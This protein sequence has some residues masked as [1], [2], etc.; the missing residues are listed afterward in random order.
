MTLCTDTESAIVDA[1]DQSA[2]EVFQMMAGVELTSIDSTSVNAGAQSATPE[3][4][5]TVVMGLSGDLQGSMIINMCETT[6][7]VWTGHLL[8]TE[9][10]SIDQ[11]VIDAVGELGNMVV[12]GAKRRLVDF[13]L[14][15]SLPSVLQAGMDRMRFPSN[16]DPIRLNYEFE[17]HP[18]CVLIALNSAS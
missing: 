18:L 9:T 6:A 16:L 12:G 10:D 17:H 11:D 13:D 8:G 3:C 5:V 15:M 2:R 4:D 7:N 1:I 14:T